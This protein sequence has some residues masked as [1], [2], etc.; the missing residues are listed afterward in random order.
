MKTAVEFE[1]LRE[2]NS[3]LTDPREEYANRLAARRA[4]LNYEQQR[5][6]NIW[7][8][9][10]VVFAVIALMIILAFERAV[11]WPLIAAP[12][13]V[14]IALMAF[15]QRIH[16][17]VARLGRAVKFYER[18]IAR[19]ED[20]WSGGGETGERFADKSHPYSEDL[21]LFG[22]GSLFEL[23]STARTR[24]G[25]ERLASWLLTPAPIPEVL[26]RQQSVDELRSRLD[27]REDLALLGDEVKAG[28]HP[29]EL[30]AW[31]GR[32]PIFI[33]RQL[34]WLRLAALLIGLFSA[35]AIVMWLGFGYRRTAMIALAVE[36]TF[37]F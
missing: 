4:A 32:P 16:A 17:A 9:R 29:E 13:I 1:T 10:R 6:R 21:D 22:E 36:A 7:F 12:V 2:R 34:N 26:A 27:L 20:D 5:S 23:L 31:A 19:I 28:A 14:F 8:W 15:H 35:V 37:L 11:A 3:T 33:E 18:G 24:A 25:E 30:V